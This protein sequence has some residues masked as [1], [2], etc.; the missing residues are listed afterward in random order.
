[1][2]RRPLLPFAPPRRR[3]QLVRQGEAGLHGYAEDEI[4][5]PMGFDGLAVELDYL[6]VG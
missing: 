5:P 3:A 6:A 1:M 2:V 4:T